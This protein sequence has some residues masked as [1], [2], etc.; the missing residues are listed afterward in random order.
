MIV[1]RQW[2]A[3]EIFYLTSDTF[4]SDQTLPN[5]LFQI[6]LKYLHLLSRY[7]IKVSSNL[8][9]FT[10]III[11]IIINNIIAF[12][13]RTFILIYTHQ[14]RITCLFPLIL[15]LIL[16]LMIVNVWYIIHRVK[17]LAWLRTC[18]VKHNRIWS[19]SFRTAETA[20]CLTFW[21]R[22]YFFEF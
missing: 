16:P 5:L 9:I 2:L 11:I 17:N 21:R 10:V 1:H 4:L 6:V 15:P 8:I 22:N 19:Q 20:L 12:I 7:D 3:S 14:P 18:D 13:V